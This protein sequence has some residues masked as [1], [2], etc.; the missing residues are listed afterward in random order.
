[1]AAKEE[2]KSEDIKAP[3]KAK[4]GLSEDMK[5]LLDMAVSSGN[6]AAIDVLRRQAK[7]SGMSEE[8]FDAL[9]AA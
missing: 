8:D 2:D 5:V 3:E 7:A 6:K 9:V 1:M 4:V